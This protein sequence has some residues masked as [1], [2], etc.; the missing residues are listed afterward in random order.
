MQSSIPSWKFDINELLLYPTISFVGVPSGPCTLDTT[1]SLLRQELKNRLIHEGTGKG[2]RILLRD[3]IFHKV[4]I[5]T[6]LRLEDIKTIQYNKR[7]P[8]AYS[9]GKW[10]FNR[11]RKRIKRTRGAKYVDED[12][13]GEDA[14]GDDLEGGYRVVDEAENE[15]VLKDCWVTEEKRNHEATILEMVKGIPNVV[16]LIDHWDVYYGEEPDC[17]LHIRSQYD[18]NHRA[19]LAFCNRFHCRILLSPCG[20]PFSS[21][22]ELLTAFHAFVAAHNAMIKNRV[23][24]GDLSPNTFIIHNS[25]GYFIDVDHASILAEGTTST[26]SLGTW[27]MP[28]ISIRILDA[29]LNLAT[30]E[31]HANISGRDANLNDVDDIEADDLNFVPQ[32]VNVGT[33]L[34]GLPA[35]R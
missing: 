27:T 14:E 5:E 7:G 26:Y 17:T 24:H 33:D 4:I 18:T 25:I 32:I 28:Y 1:Q 34:I 13:E 8:P 2:A 30:P 20:E 22:T 21:R 19:D 16:Q 15:C 31:V 3:S 9:G 11:R 29:M 6:T 35:Q 23:L 12:S 10:T